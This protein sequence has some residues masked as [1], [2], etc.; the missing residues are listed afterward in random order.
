MHLCNTIW[1]MSWQDL[2]MAYANNKDADQPAHPCSLISVFVIPSI[3]SIIPEPPHDKTNKLACAPSLI[4]VF[5]VR[6]KKAWGLSYSLS[7]QWKL[8]SDW[9]R[10]F[11]GRTVI[12]LVLS[13]GISPNFETLASFCSW[14]GCFESNLVH[15][16]EDRFTHD[17]TQMS[18][19]TR[20]P[21]FGVCDQ[22]RL[23]PACSAT[24]T[25]QRLEI[26]NIETRGEKQ[27]H[28]SDCM[29]VQADLRLCCSD[30]A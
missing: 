14:T 26:S 29:D 8:W 9:A 30:M 22:L 2:F 12:L 27:R 24:E 5:A 23:K 21:V 20:K 25:S 18:L 11:A 13:C 4:R 19:V 7:I 1:A 16:S 10:V 6:M 28:W 3:D 15:I 17:V